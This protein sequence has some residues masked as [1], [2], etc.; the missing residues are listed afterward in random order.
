MH[1]KSE[2]EKEKIPRFTV[3]ARSTPVTFPV[4]K[5]HEN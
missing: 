5:M 4:E 3:P 1:K 2:P